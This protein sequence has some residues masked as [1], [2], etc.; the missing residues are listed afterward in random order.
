MGHIHEFKRL[1]HLLR[2]EAFI[3]RRF[4]DYWYGLR[5]RWRIAFPLFDLIL[6]PDFEYINPEREESSEIDDGRHF[7]RPTKGLADLLANT[8]AES[9]SS[10]V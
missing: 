9:M 8:E 3:F 1:V 4:F 2:E 7:D 5:W 10:D 6:I